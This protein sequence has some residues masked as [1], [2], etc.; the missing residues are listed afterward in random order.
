[1]YLNHG[2]LDPDT[3]GKAD[4]A[5]IAFREPVSAA[6]LALAARSC[7]EPIH[8]FFHGDDGL[9]YCESPGDVYD[10]AV[11]DGWGR[12][13]YPVTEE[14]AAAFS[15]AVER[16]VLEI[17][18]RTPIAFFVGPGAT[19]GEDPWETWSRQQV[20]PVVV[21]WLERYLDTRPDLP[22]D[23][24]DDAVTDLDDDAIWGWPVAPM[25]REWLSYLFEEFDVDGDERLSGY[26]QRL[27]TLISRLG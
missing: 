25:N 19:L 11:V 16:W 9:F 7:P 14:A 2:P 12:G 8:G 1:M 26:A 6:N 21:P 4:G 5:W 17:H 15:A 20:G 10:V 23:D 22:Q 18:Q 3:F 24:P 27:A 13:E